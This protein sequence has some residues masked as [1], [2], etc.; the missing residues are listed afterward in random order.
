ME[1]ENVILETDFIECEI[2]EN[3]NDEIK[4]PCVFKCDICFKVYKNRSGLWKHK[5]TCKQIIKLEFDEFLET[6]K[7]I[8]FEDLE[9]TQDIKED[10]K[11]D[12]LE[13]MYNIIEKL[14]N[15]NQKI[16]ELNE[17][18]IKK[19]TVLS[20]QINILIKH[21]AILKLLLD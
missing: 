2:I 1:T 16:N 11:E 5:K 8:D 19:N 20:D 9:E 14:H 3:L 10:I 18:L 13:N 15:E 7:E 4:P 17:E 21:R 6:S 12:T